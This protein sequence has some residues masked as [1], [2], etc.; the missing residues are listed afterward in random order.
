MCLVIYLCYNFSA[1]ACLNRNIP[2][3]TTNIKDTL[4][5]PKVIAPKVISER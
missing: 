1:I 5:A 4:V 2:P 3:A